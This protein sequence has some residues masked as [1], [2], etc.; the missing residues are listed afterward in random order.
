MLSDGRLQVDVTA[1]SNHSVEIWLGGAPGTWDGVG[2]NARFNTPAGMVIDPNEPDVL[3]IADSANHQIRKVQ[4]STSTTSQWAGAHA[5]GWDYLDGIGTE[6]KLGTPWGLATHTINKCDGSRSRLMFVTEQG[7]HRVRVIDIDTVAVTTL[8]GK[9]YSGHVDGGPYTA[10]F[11][12]PTGIHIVHAGGGARAIFVTDS[13][14]YAVRK[15]GATVSMPNCAD[16]QTHASLSVSP[17]LPL[18]AN[19]HVTLKIDTSYLGTVLGTAEQ[20]WVGLY[21]AGECANADTTDGTALTNLHK[22]YLASK[23]ISVRSLTTLTFV[24]SAEDYNSQEGSYEVSRSTP[25]LSLSCDTM[26]HW[27]SPLLA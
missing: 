22:C 27:L 5:N 24:F 20:D 13:G 15:V 18:G 8:T 3:Y 7:N 1:G 26:Q 16:V 17:R 9:E 23:Q 4:I 6:A 11:S 2:T 19:V 10:R 12:Q 25:P 14:N 21:R